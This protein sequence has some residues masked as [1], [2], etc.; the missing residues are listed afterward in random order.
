MWDGGE[1]GKRLLRTDA[2]ARACRGV[3][4]APD[5]VVIATA[6]DDGQLRLW[7]ARHSALVHSFSGHRGPVLGVAYSSAGKYVA[8]ASADGSVKIWDVAM[9]QLIHT[10]SDHRA[11]VWALAFDDTGKRLV[12]GGE[13]ALLIQYTVL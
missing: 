1:A 9:R 10:F 11:P 7:D 12:S 5:S 2:H 13:D 3:A 6:S 4:F 8:S